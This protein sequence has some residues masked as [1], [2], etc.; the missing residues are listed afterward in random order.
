MAAPLMIAEVEGVKV[1][2]FQTL[3]ILDPIEVEI[4]GR[5]LCELVDEQ[6]RRKILLDFHK[7]R[8]LSSQMLGALIKLD[9]KSKAIKGKV[10]LSGLRPE[11]A[12]VFE[13]T[14]LNKILHIVAD[15]QEA[16][17]CFDGLRG[18]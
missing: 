17:S 10:V 15:E 14:R 13:V 4:I 8:Q 1:V 9:K 18:G 12:K 11:I 5:Q 3:S 7:V 6:A 16:M 2:T